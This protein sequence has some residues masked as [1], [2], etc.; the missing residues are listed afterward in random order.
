[1][2]LACSCRRLRLTA[3]SRS[4]GCDCNTSTESR[5]AGAA[6]DR[7]PEFANG[8]PLTVAKLPVPGSNQRAPTLG[9]TSFVMSMVSVRLPGVYASTALPSFTRAATARLNPAPG[10]DVST[11]PLLSGTR[12]HHSMAVELKSSGR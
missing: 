6:N 2:R 5:P 10:S 8:E 4:Q 12:L 1:M 9:P 3:H 7:L 11:L